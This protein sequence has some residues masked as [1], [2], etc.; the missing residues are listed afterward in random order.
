MKNVLYNKYKEQARALVNERLVYFNAYYGFIYGRVSI[1]NQKTRWGSCS[2]KG[3]L[4]FSYRILFLDPEEQDYLIIHELCHLKQFNHS[5]AFWDLV[6]EQSPN[7]KKH[8]LELKHKSGF[9]ILYAAWKKS[10]SSL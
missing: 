3:N 6:G 7:Y 8:H 9:R 5:Q 10:L 4:N 2:S 1:R